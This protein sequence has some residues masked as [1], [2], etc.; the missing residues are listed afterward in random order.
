MPIFL[1]ASPFSPQESCRCAD[2]NLK[3]TQREEIEFT[4]LDWFKFA[5]LKNEN[6][7]SSPIKVTHVNGKELFIEIPE[8]DSFSEDPQEFIDSTGQRYSAEEVAQWFY[9]EDSKS[10]TPKE[11]TFSYGMKYEG[12]SD[13]DP[14]DPDYTGSKIRTPSLLMNYSWGP[15]GFKDFVSE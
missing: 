5:D 10:Q 13:F 9:S 12:Y 15:P 3:E 1:E 7:N 6:F 8:S 14:C 2:C 4:I 11:K